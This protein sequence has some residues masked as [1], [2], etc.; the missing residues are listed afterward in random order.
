MKSIGI[1]GTLG[2]VDNIVQADE[3]LDKGGDG[4]DVMVSIQDRDEFPLSNNDDESMEC[5]DGK[6]S[7]K[8]NEDRESGG[9]SQVADEDNDDES[10]NSQESK[11]QSIPAV[12]ES[13]DESDSSQDEQVSNM[14]SSRR[15][16]SI[17]A[18]DESND[19]SDASQEGEDQETAAVDENIS[20]RPSR[21]KRS[22]S[23]IDDYND[24]SYGSQE[25]E[26]QNT[27]TVN[28]EVSIRSSSRKKSPSPFANEST[29]RSTREMVPTSFFIMSRHLPALTFKGVIER[30]QE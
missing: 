11:E 22:V 25:G 9:E 16:R 3:E 23:A 1:G 30:I 28:K 14:S 15:K 2:V 4:E 27:A 8:E 5:I 21:K 10:R 18:V 29:R 7:T 12:D 26:D 24:E 19:K 13:N 20:N 17:A 6:Q